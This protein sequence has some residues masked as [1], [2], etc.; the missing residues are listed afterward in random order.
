[1]RTDATGIEYRCIVDGVKDP[2][3]FE[4]AGLNPDF[5]ARS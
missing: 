2:R 5:E 4:S 1:M 3:L